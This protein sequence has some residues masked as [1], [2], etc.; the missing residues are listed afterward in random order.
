MEKTP[1]FPPCEG[2]DARADVLLTDR[3]Q[4]PSLEGRDREGLAVAWGSE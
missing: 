1:L 2:A 4:V 3:N